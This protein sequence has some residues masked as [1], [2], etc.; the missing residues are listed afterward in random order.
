MARF[1]T[2]LAKNKLRTF[3]TGFSVAWEFYAYCF[4][5]ISTGLQN[6]VKTNLK[7][8]PPIAFGCLLGQTSW[9]PIKVYFR[10]IRF[11]NADY[12]W[13]NNKLEGAESSGRYYLGSS[14]VSYQDETSNFQIRTVHPDH[15]YIEKHN[16]KRSFFK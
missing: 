13:V 12:D 15:Q 7:T 9:N 11:T 3:L 4:I 1:F 14:T 5:G 2:P 8:K 16:D 10:F 6:G